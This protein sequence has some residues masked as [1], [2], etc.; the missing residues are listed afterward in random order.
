MRVL[1]LLWIMAIALVLPACSKEDPPKP[2]KKTPVPAPAPVLAPAPAPKPP[3]LPTPD[4]VQEKEKPSP[5]VTSPEKASDVPETVAQKASY[6]LGY[7]LHET[8]G[9][10][11]DF[12]M[13]RRGFDDI[14]NGK[15]LAI[16]KAEM[17]EALRIFQAEYHL[18]K[19]TAYLE[20]N[21]KKEGVT[22][23][24]SG[25]QYSVQESGAGPSPVATDTVTVHYTGTLIDG[26]VFDSSVQRNQPASFSLNGVIKGWTEG[27]QLMKMGAKYTFTIPSDLA[28]GERAQRSIPANSTLIFTVE[29]L[30]IRGK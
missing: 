3:P 24:P 30:S 1:L 22:T 14:L 15:D 18:A 13:L 7:Q 23:L 28:Y 19:Q 25:L 11:L 6:S 12:E 29:L 17:S 20:A 4:P 5:E 27:L 26:T 9:P 21:G 2:E 8:F 10:K 16:D